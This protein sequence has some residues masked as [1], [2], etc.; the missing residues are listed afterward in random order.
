MTDWGAQPPT[1]ISNEYLQAGGIGGTES[2]EMLNRNLDGQT[3]PK[4][5]V[6]FLSRWV[7]SPDFYPHNTLHLR[8][9]SANPKVKCIE[10]SF[11]VRL[12]VCMLAWYHRD[13]SDFIGPFFSIVLVVGQSSFEDI[14]PRYI[15]DVVSILIVDLKG[16]KEVLISEFIG[17]MN[18]QRCLRNHYCSCWSSIQR[19]VEIDR[20]RLE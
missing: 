18:I 16:N 1:L 11:L 20:R 14:L 3:G 6:P 8:C 5:S 2:R 4:I 12:Q 13:L 9:Y 7:N 10:N 17:L 15:G 19:L